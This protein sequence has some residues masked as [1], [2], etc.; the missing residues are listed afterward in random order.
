[1]LVGQSL[2]VGL[3]LLVGTVDVD[4]CDPTAK[5][6]S[7]KSITHGPTLNPNRIFSFQK[8][9]RGVDP[10]ERWYRNQSSTAN[11][12]KTNGNFSYG[13]NERDVCV[14]DDAGARDEGVWH[15]LFNSIEYDG[16]TDQ[17]THPSVVVWVGAIQYVCVHDTR[18]VSVPP[19]LVSRCRQCGLARFVGVVCLYTV[20]LYV[21]RLWRN[22]TG[23]SAA[24]VACSD[25][26]NR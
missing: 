15:N 9:I 13:T 26:N 19:P 11:E 17:Q 16:L 2:L 25:W 7:Q 4:V 6:R 1:M 12:R 18:G 5:T 24:A 8:K 22:E 14:G 20:S 21:F 10:I 3:C 23:P